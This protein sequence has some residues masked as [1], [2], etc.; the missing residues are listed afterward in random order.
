MKYKIEVIMNTDLTEKKLIDYLEMAI[1]KELEE[2]IENIS[3]S[4][5]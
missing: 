1:E 3:I 4:K 2:R 5:L